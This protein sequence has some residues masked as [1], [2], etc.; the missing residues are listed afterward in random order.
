V[1]LGVRLGVVYAAIALVFL[2]FITSSVRTLSRI[3]EDVRVILTEDESMIAELDR[4]RAAFQDAAQVA[5]LASAGSSDARR[6]R[7]ARREAR[8]LME[9]A[10]A[11]GRP[12][13]SKP[14]FQIRTAWSGAALA[15][16]S[17]ERSPANADQIYR[18]RV[19]P[20]LTDIADNLNAVRQR[21]REDSS[22]RLKGI[23]KAVQQAWA[24]VP[25]FAL[26]ALAALGVLLYLVRWGVVS[27]LRHLTRAAETLAEGDLTHRVAV[28]RDDEIGHLARRFNDMAGRLSSMERMKTEFLSMVSH[29]MRT[30]L[31]LIG[32]YAS[33][34]QKT[35]DKPDPVRRDK[36]LDII[37]NET[38]QLQFLVEDILDAARAETGVFRIQ[39]APADAAGVLAM[40]L[41]PLGRHAEQKK[42]KFS[43]DIAVPP[44]V[45]DAKRLGQALR[46]LATN[47]LKFTPEG[48]RVEVRGRVEGEELV[49]EVA[50]TGPGILPE[51]LPHVFTRFY[52]SPRR[53]GAYGGAGL[54]LA[55]VREIAQAHGGEVEVESR[56]D[57]GAR[58]RLRIPY[59][60]AE[61]FTPE[62]SEKEK[63]SL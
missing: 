2:I 1:K 12:E 45:V 33:I 29:E 31:T 22:A 59:K 48:G 34:L 4:L 3:S 25:A 52:Q 44:A 37:L 19:L 23:H 8:R 5:R 36:A 16:E 41:E 60:P 42:V 28:E 27:P 55:V 53:A 63:L 24:A 18:D 35:R 50:D 21:R 51:D 32:I 40:L 13:E 49:F 20:A 57:Q 56:P 38:K 9:A 11:R 58:F 6:A 43:H 61:S 7:A 14:F 54:G 39:P 46:N 15:L 62:P 17:L 30:P 47:A 10:A 26:L